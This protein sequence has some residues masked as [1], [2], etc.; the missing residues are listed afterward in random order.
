VRWLAASLALLCAGCARRPAR[1]APAAAATICDP[2]VIDRA[3]LALDDGDTRAAE[4]GVAQAARCPRSARKLAL[5]AAWALDDGRLDEAVARAREAL[6]LDGYDPIVLVEVADALRARNSFD[7]AAA[8]AERAAAVAGTRQND[9]RLLL[10]EIRLDADMTDLARHALEALP[11]PDALLPREALRAGRLWVDLGTPARAR[12]YLDRASRDEGRLTRAQQA[13]LHYEI[14]L[15]FDRAG[16]MAAKIAEF[17]RVWDLEHD[18]P[19]PRPAPSAE[20]FERMVREQIAELP[21]AERRLLDRVTVSVAAYPAAEIVAEGFDPRSLGMFTG[22]SDAGGKR[23]PEVPGAIFLY[24]KNLI[25]VARHDED[26]RREI[27]RTLLHELGHFRG[28]SEDDLRAAR[29]Q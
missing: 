12:P 19:P 17:R 3:L 18:A 11:A 27:H 4:R 28:L 14:G 22:D 15:S 6:A 1:P 20:A 26:L 9:A 21:P 10:A 8:L 23:R 7:E 16:R 13:D 24:R 5:Q 2:G 25:A 29:L